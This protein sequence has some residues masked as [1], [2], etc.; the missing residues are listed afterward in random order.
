MYSSSE[1]PI[2]VD[3]L[4]KKQDNRIWGMPYKLEAWA[5]SHFLLYTDAIRYCSAGREKSINL[6]TKAFAKIKPN[7][8]VSGNDMYCK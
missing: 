5:E 1:E 4:H 6:D 2:L 7:V 8:N 3:T